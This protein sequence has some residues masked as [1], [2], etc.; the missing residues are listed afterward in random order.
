[1]TK[2][3]VDSTGPLRIFL[4]QLF[5]LFLKTKAELNF[6]CEMDS[7]LHIDFLNRK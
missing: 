3:I 6:K 2:F 5:I 1:M 4:K 7:H